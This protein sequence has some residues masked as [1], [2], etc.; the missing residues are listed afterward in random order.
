MKKPNKQE[1]FETVA[2]YDSDFKVITRHDGEDI[3]EH[4]G[5]RNTAEHLI[6]YPETLQTYVFPLIKSAGLGEDGL[7][8][9][10][11]YI[12]TSKK[13]GFLYRGLHNTLMLLGDMPLRSWSDNKLSFG[14]HYKIKNADGCNIFHAYM[15]YDEGQYG[16]IKFEVYYQGSPVLLFDY[17]IYRHY[18]L[19]YNAMDATLNIFT[20]LESAKTRYRPSQR[21]FDIGSYMQIP[22]SLRPRG[23]FRIP[24]FPGTSNVASRKV[25]HILNKMCC[26]CA[27]YEYNKY[28][29][30]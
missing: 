8:F 7:Y 24:L 17:Y 22:K 18:S 5:F 23:S 3:P 30:K 11:E 16:D 12:V 20:A 6:P 14:A 1:M 4:C 28:M 2:K 10:R 9:E 15:E 26:L 21:F 13:R 19:D 25:R 27:E 29:G